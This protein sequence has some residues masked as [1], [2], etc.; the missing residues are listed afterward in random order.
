[1]AHVR[2]LLRLARAEAQLRASEARLREILDHVPVI[3]HIKDTEGR[4]LLVNRPWEELFHKGR[5]QVVGRSVH[6]VHPREQA[7]AFRANDR[8]G[9]DGRAPL[10]FEERAALADGPHTF[11][12]IKFPLCDAAGAPYAVCGVS[13][14]ITDR[15]RAE[16]ALRESEALYHS[17][18]ENLPL[19]I[20][21]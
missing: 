10:Q 8:K 16:E 6:D 3:V 11:L 12:S 18:V 15:K 21:R 19:C 13:A 17:L 14:D 4:Y 7:H 1:V 9:L 20:F 2:A 5:D